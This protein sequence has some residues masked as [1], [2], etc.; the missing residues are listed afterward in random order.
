MTAK[1]HRQSLSWRFYLDQRARSFRAALGDHEV[2]ALGLLLV[3]HD[4]TYRA[5]G[6]DDGRAGRVGHER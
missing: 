1:S 5:N 2:A 4:L 6:V 3:L